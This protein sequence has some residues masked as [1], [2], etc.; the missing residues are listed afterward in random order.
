MGQAL[1]GPF[2][3]IPVG[4]SERVL[5]EQTL[6]ISANGGASN[7]HIPQQAS[8]SFDLAVQPGRQVLLVVITET[9]WQAVSAGEK[10]EGLP[11]LRTNVSGIDTKSVQMQGGN[12]VVAVLGVGNQGMT[13]V[14]LR[15]RIRAL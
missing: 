10:A 1:A 15:A 7:L 8:V 4:P 13:Q 5:L 11:V 3:S 6:T 9:Q 12:Y 14:S 2:D